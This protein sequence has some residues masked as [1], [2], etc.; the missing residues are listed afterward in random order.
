MLKHTIKLEMPKLWKKRTDEAVEDGIEVDLKD[1]K[2][3]ISGSIVLGAT[4]TVGIGIGFVLG[5]NRA[6]KKDS[7]VFIIK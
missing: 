2:I 7:N 5:K 6:I 3:H 1:K 4:L